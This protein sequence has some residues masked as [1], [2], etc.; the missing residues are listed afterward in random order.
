M[1]GGRATLHRQDAQVGRLQELRH[2]GL[3]DL[4]QE[5]DGVAQAEVT[6][7]RHEPVPIVRERGAVAGDEQLD[8]PVL[9]TE[10]SDRLEQRVQSLALTDQPEVHQ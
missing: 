4:A 1:A 7:E 2:L 5:P 6:A 9:S 10:Q 3:G 8:Q